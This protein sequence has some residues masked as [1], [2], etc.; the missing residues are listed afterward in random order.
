MDSTGESGLI[1]DE[2]LRRIYDVAVEWAAYNGCP[3]PRSIR[4]VSTTRD[5]AT[6]VLHGPQVISRPDDEIYLVVVE[7]DLVLQEAVDRGAS[8]APTGSW[9]ALIVRRPAVRVGGLT[10]RPAEAAVDIGTLGR[11]YTLTD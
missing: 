10:L 1:P 4:V 3:H 8:R 6:K 7:G 9:A 5:A 11:I 2:E